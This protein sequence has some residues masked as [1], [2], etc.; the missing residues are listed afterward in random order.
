MFI[1][2][3][4]LNEEGAGGS[5]GL[6]T[7]EEADEPG[8]I[9]LATEHGGKIEIVFILIVYILNYCVTNTHFFL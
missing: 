4:A 6:I 9:S 1:F 8:G 7:W 2:Q 5:R 3:E